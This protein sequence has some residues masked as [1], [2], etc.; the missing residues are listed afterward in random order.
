MCLG[1]TCRVVE[2]LDG[3]LVRVDSG[4]RELEVSLLALDEP[5]ARDDWV[6][7][8]AGFALARLT[9]AQVTDAAAV[10]DAIREDTT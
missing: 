3:G 7:V 10:R 5:V 2:V 1:L 6:L 8:H 9:D 4:E